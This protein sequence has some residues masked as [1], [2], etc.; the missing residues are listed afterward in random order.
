MSAFEGLGRA[1][2]E[3]RAQVREARD[4]L[5]S[6]RAARGGGPARNAAEAERQLLALRDAITDD[7][8]MLRERL[9]GQD[10]AASRARRN[11]ALGVSGAIAGVVGAALIGRRAVTRGSQRRS[12]ER[13]A[14]ALARALSEQTLRD[15]SDGSAG[16]SNERSRGGGVALLA[17]AGAVAAGVLMAQRRNVPIDE[18]DLWL[19]VEPTGP[20]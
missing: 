17:A 2:E 5:A 19:P 15:R 20:V 14:V 9:G 12:V 11:T 16:R 18:D 6:S 4:A 3:A 8:R 7:V 1:T 10:P 13:Q